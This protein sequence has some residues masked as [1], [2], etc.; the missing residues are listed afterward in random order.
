MKQ[1]IYLKHLIYKSLAALLYETDRIGLTS[2][3]QF[4][5]GLLRRAARL[6]IRLEAGR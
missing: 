4:R 5:L 1:L 2:T 3:Y 6:T